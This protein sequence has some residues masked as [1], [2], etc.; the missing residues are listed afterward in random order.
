[1][2]PTL[3]DAAKLGEIS[4]FHLIGLPIPVINAITP[5]ALQNFA[6]KGYDMLMPMMFMTNM[7]IAGATFAMFFKAKNKME[8]SI[9]ISATISA[10][11]GITEPALFGVLIKNKKAFIACTIGSAIA[12]TFFAATGV[13]IYGYILSSIVCLVAYVVPYFPYA[14]AG[15]IIAIGSSF[16]IA[17]FTIKKNGSSELNDRVS[18]AEKI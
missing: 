16:L 15:I 9:I 2:Y 6:D 12:A 5:I 7:A 8:K 1:M 13:R 18:N 3:L 14:I 4:Q 17:Y 11:L 10:L